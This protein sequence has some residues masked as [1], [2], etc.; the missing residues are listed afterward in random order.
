MNPKALEYAKEFI[1]LCPNDTW[2]ADRQAKLFYLWGHSYEY[3]RDN[4][5]ELLDKLCGILAGNENIWYATNMEI[6]EY[7]MAYESL[8][9]SSDNKIVYNPS[10]KEVWFEVDTKMYSIK[11]G[12]TLFC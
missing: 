2:L 1:A 11:S 3:D 4:N 7:M 5:W 9:F 6:Y 12:E 8:E 10:L